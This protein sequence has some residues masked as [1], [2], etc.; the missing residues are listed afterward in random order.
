MG[1]HLD[2]DR[3][4]H[5]DGRGGCGL[6]DSGVTCS[7]AVSTTTT[8]AASGAPTTVGASSTKAEASLDLCGIGVLSQGSPPGGFCGCGRIYLVLHGQWPPPRQ[9]HAHQRR[10]CSLHAHA[11]MGTAEVGGRPPP[12][13]ARRPDVR[14]RPPRETSNE[15]RKERRK[16][17]RAMQECGSAEHDCSVPERSG[18]RRRTSSG[19]EKGSEHRSSP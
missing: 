19:R 2:L 10:R 8:G 18:E 7:A 13:Q 17:T 15:R 14:T 5:D 12:R 16:G 9:Q 4:L 3:G 1:G 6:N 11:W